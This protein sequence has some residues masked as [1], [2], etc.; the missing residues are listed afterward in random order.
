LVLVAAFVLIMLVLANSAG[1]L[2]HF[3]SASSTTTSTSS[4][5]PFPSAQAREASSSGPAVACNYT[6]SLN[7]TAPVARENSGAETK[8]TEG[9]DVGAFLN[10]LL[11]SH[12]TYCF[13]AG[14]YAVGTEIQIDHLQGVT[15]SLNPGGV[16]N[17]TS[18]N[19]LLL[20]YASLGTVVRGGDWIGPGRGNA[21]GIIRIQ[22]GSN[23]TVVEGASVSKSGLDGILIYDNVRPSFN[24]SILDNTLYNNGRYGVQEFSNTT[25]GMMGTVISGNVALNNEVGGIYTNGI[26]GATITQNVVRNTAGNGPGEIGIGVTNGHNDTVSLNQ[27]SHMAWFGIQAYYNNYTVMTDNVSMFNTGAEDQSGITNDHSS[28]STIVGNVVESNGDYG[29]YVERSWNVTISGNIAN[30]NYGYGIALYHGSLPASGRSAIV[31]NICS[32]NWLGG[33]IL[34]SAIDNV[35]SMNQC[36]NNSGDGIL[37]YNDPGQVGST[38]NL[39]SDNWL[40]ND[41]NSSQTQLFGIREA[42]ESDNNTLSLNVMVNNTEAATSTL[43]PGATAAP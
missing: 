9:T 8:D 26:A 1:A 13:A 6:I 38:G 20:V 27:V 42:N 41:G 34:N 40:G 3:S 23:D 2:T 31:G 4:S 29:I 28:Y 30:G 24:V 15:L 5:Q 25:T 35:I 37:L 19:R 21:S 14:D 18:D 17:A 32:L 10:S 36:S 22:Y 16:M 33:I 7:G 43:G 11:A 12:E 39:V